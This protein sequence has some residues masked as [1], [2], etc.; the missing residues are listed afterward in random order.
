MK[1]HF[2]SIKSALLFALL[3]V[4]IYVLVKL[5]KEITSYKFNTT[6]IVK[7]NFIK[8]AATY[9]FPTQKQTDDTPKITASGKRIG[10]NPLSQRMIGM[11]RDLIK[12]YT[13]G[14]PFNYGDTIVVTGCSAFNGMWVLY[15]CAPLYYDG[16]LVTNRIDFLVDSS[17]VL[18]YAGKRKRILGED[19]TGCVVSNCLIDND[20]VFIT[21]FQRQ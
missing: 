2:D 13:I 8:V 9:Y 11:S 21:K 7:S 17:N 4:L 1:I 10:L 19:K 6:Y 18:K 12:N 16:E 15:D 3:L 14:A 5:P 20:S